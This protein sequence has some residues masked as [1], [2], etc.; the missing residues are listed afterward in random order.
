MVEL[1]RLIEL[2][3][4]LMSDKFY[5]KLHIHFECGKI[6]LLIEEKYIK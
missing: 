6:V 3:K 1:S 5:G 2:I 4:K